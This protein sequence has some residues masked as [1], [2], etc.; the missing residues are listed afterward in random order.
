MNL[1]EFNYSRKRGA[2]RILCRVF[3]GWGCGKAG[4]FAQKGVRKAAALLLGGS[5]V[6]VRWAEAWVALG[7]G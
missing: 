1:V 5:A 7:A 2:G 6:V 4:L 3:G